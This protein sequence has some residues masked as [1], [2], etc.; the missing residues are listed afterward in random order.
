MKN[1]FQV[2]IK[3]AVIFKIF[4]LKDLE[5]RGNIDSLTK[6]PEVVTSG[7]LLGTDII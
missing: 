4:A 7:L 1:T 6:S 5:S 3:F 2:H